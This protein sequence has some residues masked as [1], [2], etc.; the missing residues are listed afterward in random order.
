M[1]FGLSYQ[2]TDVDDGSH[3]IDFSDC[4]NAKKA[5]IRNIRRYEKKNLDLCSII[6][7]EKLDVT[8]ALLAINPQ[9]ADRSSSQILPFKAVCVYLNFK[10]TSLTY[11]SLLN[12]VSVLSVERHRG[13]VFVLTLME[14]VSEEEL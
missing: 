14:I 7:Y 1:N 9:I 6:D 13:N 5:F 3:K 8:L 11:S 12:D 4:N 2:T 10:K